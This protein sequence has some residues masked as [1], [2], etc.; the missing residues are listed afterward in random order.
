MENNLN[1]F[2]SFPGLKTYFIQGFE[3]KQMST[4]PLDETGDY[5]LSHKQGKV[6]IVDCWYCKSKCS[7]Y[8]FLNLQ[9]L[10]S[11]HELDMLHAVL[12]EFANTAHQ[13]KE[14][15]YGTNMYVC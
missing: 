11:Q 8:E 9:L 6:G 14:N 1:S 3:H 7:V 5:Y 12:G 2:F 10:R 13:E 15:G 4:E